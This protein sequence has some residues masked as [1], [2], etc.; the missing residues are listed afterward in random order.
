MRI[1]HI[2]NLRRSEASWQHR[3][4]LSMRG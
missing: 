1:L 3:C 2:T 4:G